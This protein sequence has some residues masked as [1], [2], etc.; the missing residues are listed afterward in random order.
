MAETETPVVFPIDNDWTRTVV[1]GTKW[2]F[3]TPY[4][5]NTPRDRNGQIVEILR[6]I[7]SPDE[8][9]DEDVLPMAEVR[10][11]DGYEM[12]VYPEELVV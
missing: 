2:E 9:Y 11:P 5:V 3:Q 8:S 10:F 6:V 7:V 1:P 12:S 4:E